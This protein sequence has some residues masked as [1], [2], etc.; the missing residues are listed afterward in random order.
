[1]GVPAYVL[2]LIGSVSAL[3][4]SFFTNQKNTKGVFM[5][6]AAFLSLLSLPLFLSASS[7]E[8]TLDEK[9]NFQADL[10]EG[11]HNRLSVTN[12]KISQVIANPHFF[13]ITINDKLGLVFVN[14]KKPFEDP[15]ALSVVTESG[16]VQDFLF[17]TVKKEP[18]TIFISEPEEPVDEL[19]I[20]NS[21]ANAATLCEIFDGKAPENYIRRDPFKEEMIPASESILYFIKDVTVFEGALENLYVLH[22]ENEQRKPLKIDLENFKNKGINWICAP[23]NKLSRHE[24]TTIVISKE[25]E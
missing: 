10:A 23:K 17:K 2:S 8:I 11:Y 16:K 20:Q 9:K 1:M 4:T 25:K 3:I 6:K 5:K 21:L 12:G 19:I 15:Q 22:I 24:T 14:A 13:D 7:V 18:V